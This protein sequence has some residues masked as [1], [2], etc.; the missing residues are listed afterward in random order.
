MSKPRYRLQTVLE[1]R[2]R[3]RDAAQEALAQRLAE[4]DRERRR[5]A[6]LESE[7]AAGEQELAARREAIHEP[8]AGGTLA[9]ATIER[10]RAEVQYLAAGHP[11]GTCPRRGGAAG[12]PRGQV[13]RGC[14]AAPPRRGDAPGAGGRER[15]GGGDRGSR[16]AGG[17][18]A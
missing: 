15:R 12:H 13:P 11:R 5:L 7:L 18:G 1:L 17:R 3:E 4:E 9:V 6:E 2:E 10:R 8:E 14:P 16:V